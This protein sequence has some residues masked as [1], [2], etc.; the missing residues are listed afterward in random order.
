LG[1]SSRYHVASLAA[2]FLAL[3]IGILIGVG[4][5]DDVITGTSKGLERSLKGDLQ[6]SRDQVDDLGAELDRERAFGERAYPALVGKR[7]K[8][9]RVFL[10]A[11]GGVPSQL[12][13]DVEAAIEP[14]GGHLAEVGVVSLPPD[15]HGLADS[16]KGTRFRRLDK[17]PDRLERF[18]RAAG[19][20]LV[21]GGPLVRRTRDELLNRFSGRA[22]RADDVILV[23]EP[24]DGSE[25]DREREARDSLEAGLLDGIH[26]SDL[27]AVGVERSD[28][29]QSS[30][31][32][33]DSHGMPTVDDLDLISGRVAMVFAL[34]GAD[35]N[36]GV[37]G[38]A[39]QL[40]PD[41]LV[42][43]KRAGAG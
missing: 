31:S 37:K 42:S 16:L 39:D 18:G 21:Q 35:G 6:D 4:F 25:S 7:L 1:Y 14:T 27:P 5:G 15:T 32:L 29:D 20:Q 43:P 17:N 28:A 11:L 30:V 41:L 22:R 3:A 36:F 26:A 10:I 12:S 34:L 13:G 33:F 40:L 38:T 23:R 2:I 9:D 19:R 24:P 8:S